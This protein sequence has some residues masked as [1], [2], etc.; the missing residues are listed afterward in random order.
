MRKGHARWSGAAERRAV[1]F[2]LVAIATDGAQLF[3]TGSTSV[4]TAQDLSIYAG[5]PPLVRTG[6]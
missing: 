3:G 4:R 1:L 5:L 6:D 2:K